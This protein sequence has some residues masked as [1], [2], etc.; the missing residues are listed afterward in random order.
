MEASADAP[1]DVVPVMK[2]ARAFLFLLCAASSC[3]DGPGFL[4][5]VIVAPELPPAWAGAD[6][7][8]LSWRCDDGS[9]GEL[10]LAPGGSAVLALPRAGEAAILCRAAFGDCLT[11]PYGALWP[12][13]RDTD[14]RVEPSAE[15]GYAASLLWP[16]LGGGA[17]AFNVGRFEAEALSRLP[18]P[19]DVDPASLAEA[20]AERRFRADYLSPPPRFAAAVTGLPRTLAP[21]S[22]WGSPAL[23]DGT[24][25]ASVVMAPGVRRWMGGGW[26]LVVSM[27]SEGQAL[28]TLSR[29]VSRS[30]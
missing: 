26:R 12:L 20:V 25:A 2:P 8:A 24:G 9:G 23:P 18:D 14:G 13:D 21:D 16:L 3:G 4:D 6:G 11:L 22:P 27:S 28:W 10:G 17:P 15:G 19:W 29:S 5:A 1:G 7:W 30:P